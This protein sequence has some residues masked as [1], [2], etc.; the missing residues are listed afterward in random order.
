MC[1]CPSVWHKHKSGE[2][3]IV[4]DKR[5]V[6]RFGQPETEK[7]I[8][9][10]GQTVITRKCHKMQMP[11]FVEVLQAFAVR[12]RH[13]IIVAQNARDVKLPAGV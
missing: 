10:Q 7:V 6:Q 8:C 12:I 11:G 9:Q 2:L 5:F 4:D 13:R 3:D 1:G